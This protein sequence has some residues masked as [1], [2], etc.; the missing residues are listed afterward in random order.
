MKYYIGFDIGGT[1]S[2]VTLGRKTENEMQ[3]VQKQLLATKDYSA[4]EALEILINKAQEFRRVADISGIGISCGGPLDSRK[5]VILSPPNLPGWDDIKI[6]EILKNRFELP[7]FL[8]NDAN[9]CAVAEWVYGAGKG[10]ENLVFLTFGTGFGAGLILNGRLY[11]GTNDLAGE[12]GHWRLCDDGPV[13]YGK[14]GSFEGFCSGEGIARLTR[15]RVS[16]GGNPALLKKAGSLENI[17]AKLVG[18]CAENGDE[19][20][21]RIYADCGRWLGKGLALVIDM[22]N[23]QLIIIGS[24]FTRSGGLLWPYAQKEI[25][26]EALPQSSGVCRMVPAKLGESIGDIAALTVA[27]GKY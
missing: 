25:E 1:K 24:I 14:A 8:Q 26:K 27:A 17:T 20:C 18:D 10:Y 11:T 19:F 3:I 2:S 16:A 7:V 23:P 6:V 9:A 5:G 12:I 4:V 22:I 21:R 15:E 13:G